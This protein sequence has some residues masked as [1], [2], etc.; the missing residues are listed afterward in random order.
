MALKKVLLAYNGA[1]NSEQD[2]QWGL[3]FVRKTPVN[4]VIVKVI[5]PQNLAG[6]NNR[7]D[8]GPG[9]VGPWHGRNNLLDIAANAL[10]DRE[11]SATTTILA[12]DTTTEIIQFAEREH[13][14][15]ILYGSSGFA[16]LGSSLPA[17]NGMVEP[18]RRI[19]GQYMVYSLRAVAGN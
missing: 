13:V 4:T 14:D 15:L 3:N 6:Y 12:G 7:R 1:V 19:S 10:E 11:L 8:D 17:G 9:S 16:G 2:L 18:E 5:E